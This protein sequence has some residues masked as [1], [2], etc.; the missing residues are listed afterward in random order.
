MSTHMRLRRPST[1]SSGQSET[2]TLVI[3]RRIQRTRH[4]NLVPPSNMDTRV[5]HFG[6]LLFGLSLTAFGAL[7]FVHGDFVTRVVPAWPAWIPPRML[8]VVL[9]GAIL[10]AAG[11]AVIGGLRPR[12][13]LWA[14]AVVLVFSI[15][16]FHLPSLTRDVLIGGNW[17]NTGKTLALLGGCLAV[18]S[19][20]AEDTR[21]KPIV[22]LFDRRR[23]HAIGRVCLAVFMLLAGAQHFRW[24]TFVATLVPAWIPG[25]GLFWAYGTA[26][27]LIAGGLGLLIPPTTRPAALGSGVMIFLWVFMVHLPRV[28][29]G[30][31]SRSNETT[32]VF[33]ALGISGLAFL[34]TATVTRPHSQGE[35]SR[36]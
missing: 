32:A 25:G 19:T 17:S 13:L 6:R 29:Q 23:S 36:R 28:V 2:R 11:V 30:I 24:A 33:E 16:L 18:A 5:M 4:G 27:L 31:G 8:W 26:V 9:T 1:T 15:A 12:P 10:V 21:D 34:Y 7:H 3:L 22:R 14:I 20:F 35:G